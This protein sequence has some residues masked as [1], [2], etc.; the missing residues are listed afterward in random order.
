VRVEIEVNKSRFIARA[1]PAASVEAARACIAQVRA[2]MPDASHHV[3]AYRVG[4]GDSVIDGMSDAGEPSGTAGPP[5][6]AVLRGAD[7]GDIVVVVTRYFGGIKLGTGGLVRVYSDAVRTA[8]AQLP[9]TL[10][11]PR[12]T[13]EFVVSYSQYQLVPRLLE[14]AVA[15]LLDEQFAEQVRIQARLP[16]AN[17]PALA[18]A[19]GEISS[20]TIQVK[21]L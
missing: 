10:R 2:E 8:L 3:Y 20:G 4:Y 17:L 16:E 19:L 6:L 9:V 12:T 7:I 15:E 11:I 18:Q 13:I 14:R 21:P 1:G 5:A